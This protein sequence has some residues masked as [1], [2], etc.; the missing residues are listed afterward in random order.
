MSRPS[1]KVVARTESVTNGHDNLGTI[2][3]EAGGCEAR[4]A[5][6]AAVGTFPDVAAARKAL[7]LRSLGAGAHG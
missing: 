4:G 2:K 6:G 7:Y 3:I 5:D 1:A